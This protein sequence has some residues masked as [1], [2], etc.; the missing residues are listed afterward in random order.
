MIVDEIRQRLR[1]RP[2]SPFVLR[3]KDGRM[4]LVPDVG[5]MSMSPNGRFGVVCRA[6]RTS[7]HIDPSEAVAVEPLDPSSA[8]DPDRL[9]AAVRARPFAPLRLRLAD[10]RV[11]PVPHPEWISVAPNGRYAVL[12]TEQSE[13]IQLDMPL[14]I[15]LEN[16]DT[17]PE[18]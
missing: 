6:D 5:W 18:T 16:G 3:M 9:R 10:G 17:A 11:F 7:P 13:T 2:F 14:I 8:I 12:H 4:F 15:A 1:A